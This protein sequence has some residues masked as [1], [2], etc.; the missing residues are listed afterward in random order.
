MAKHGQY[1]NT[2]GK[3]HAQPKAAS[4]IHQLR[5]F[6]VIQGG[7]LR[8]QSHTAFRA[9]ARPL[10][11]HFGVHGASV[12]GVAVADRFLGGL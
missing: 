7:H 5:I 10:L 2:E 11:A 3:R 4:K 8:L 6:S 9:S 12:P 1:K